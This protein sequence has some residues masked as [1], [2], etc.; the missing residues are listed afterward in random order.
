LKKKA[1]DL[2]CGC[3]VI[4]HIHQSTGDAY[5]TKSGLLQLLGRFNWTLSEALK[6]THMTFRAQLPEFIVACLGVGEAPW[7]AS[8]GAM[9][10]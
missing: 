7:A 2:T 4:G 9:C 8:S 10:A 3:Q 6:V 1:L 5:V